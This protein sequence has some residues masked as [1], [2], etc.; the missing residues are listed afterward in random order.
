MQVL[1]TIAPCGASSDSSSCCQGLSPTHPCPQAGLF[2]CYS[3]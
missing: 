1:A 2:P 3:P